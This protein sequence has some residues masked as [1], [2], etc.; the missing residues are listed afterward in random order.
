MNINRIG[1]VGG[2]LMGSGIAEVGSRAG[3]QVINVDLYPQGLEN[4]KKR[5]EKDTS[6]LF[7]KGKVTKEEAES[8]KKRITYSSDYN[9]LEDCDVVIEAIPENLEMKQTLF[10]TLDEIVKAEGI[11]VTNT[12]ALSITD[13]GQNMNNPERCIG[14]H[15]FHPAPVMKLVEII[16]SNDTDDETFSKAMYFVEAIGKTPAL[17]PNNFGFIVNRIL[18]PMVNEAAY[19]VMEGSK[20]EDVDVAMK[21]G[22]NHPMG[23]LELCDYT[24]VDIMLG[25]M[26]GLYEG[27]KDE[28]YKP[29]PLLQEMVDQGKCGRKTGVGFYQYEM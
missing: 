5:I 17:A 28:K 2:G 1:V 15:F 23:P 29:C 14:L 12:S 20:P 18:V 6:Y 4:S 27:F 26:K 19:L 21:L 11:L 25:T 10:K 8:I 3:F 13:I 24:G 7:N 9:D 16:R 22:A